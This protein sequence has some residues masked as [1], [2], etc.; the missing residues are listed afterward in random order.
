MSEY[1]DTRFHTLLYEAAGNYKLM[2]VLLDLHNV[3][4]RIWFHV[5]LHAMSFSQQ[6][7]NLYAVLDA[8]EAGDPLKAR[9]A[10]EAHVD[11]YAV[12]VKNKFL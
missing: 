12:S 1:Y 11:L 5:G 10:M 3:M 2:K 4:L 6:A 7:Q 9:Q 8:L